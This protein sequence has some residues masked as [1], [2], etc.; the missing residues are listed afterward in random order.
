MATPKTVQGESVDLDLHRPTDKP[1]LPKLPPGGPFLYK[2]HPKRWDVLDEGVKA[3]PK[4]RPLLGKLKA[5]EGVSNV[6]KDGNLSQARQN[7][8]TRGWH[9][10]G[11]QQVGTSYLVKHDVNGGS[12]YVSVF[13]QVFPGS[14]RIRC[15]V[16]AYYTWLDELMDNGT[17]EPPSIHVLEDLR[18]QY[19]ERSTRYANNGSPGA[20][21]KAER[22]AA[23]V[24]VID[25][26][27]QALLEAGNAA[28]GE[29][30]DPEAPKAPAKKATPKKGA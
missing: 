13:E 12:A 24:K 6:Q 19:V 29:A 25:A 22:T 21:L 20:M 11:K 3:P 1:N 15:D 27:I 14:A 7:A 10:L 4:V 23:R 5:V 17:I 26:A 9:I 18:E 28:A 2:W 30:V 8:E 16:D